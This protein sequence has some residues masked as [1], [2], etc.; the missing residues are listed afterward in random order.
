MTTVSIYKAAGS[1]TRI[2]IS[3]HSGFAT[4]SED[5]VCAAVTSAVRY[6]E[7]M[8]N[9][10]MKLGIPFETDPDTAFI[11]FNCPVRSPD[12]ERFFGCSLA[13]A[14]F[15]QYMKELSAEY[16]NYIKVME[17]HQNA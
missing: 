7:V 3:G 10:V 6:T 4:E 1:I 2:E 12:D 13:S 17:V 16:P 11:A 14:G 8:L 15:G 9:E 5:I